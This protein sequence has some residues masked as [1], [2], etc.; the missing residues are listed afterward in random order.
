VWP[1]DAMSGDIMGRLAKLGRAGRA[2]WLSYP[3]AGH[4]LCG[5]GSGPIRYDEADEPSLGGGL[6]SAD[7]RDPGEA[8]EAT[9]AFLNA[10]L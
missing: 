6:V 4:F 5:N 9:L 1:S 2:T 3:D 7:G 8:W 10:G